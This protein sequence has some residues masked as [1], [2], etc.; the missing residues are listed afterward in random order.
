MPSGPDRTNSIRLPAVLAI[1]FT[2]HRNLKDEH[3]LRQQ[4]RDF[5]RQQQ[6]AFQG[7]VYGVS[8]AAAGGDQLFAESCL[9]LEIPLRVL[10]PR[11]AEQFRE[12]FDEAAWRRDCGATN[13]ADDLSDP[14]TDSRYLHCV[15][16]TT[17][18]TIQHRALLNFSVN[19]ESF[20][21]G[22]RTAGGGSLLVTLTHQ[23]K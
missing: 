17:S 9:E 12:D 15:R 11:P 22:E 3:K 19:P 8:S 16:D 20:A 13:L 18:E 1:G 10:L 6:N 2:G 21:G 14:D 23:G 7:F 5:L 4:I